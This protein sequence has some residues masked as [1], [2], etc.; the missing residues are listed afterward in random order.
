MSLIDRLHSHLVHSR[1]VRVLS[2]HFA[3]LI[4]Q[5]SLVLDVGCGD[6]L[7]AHWIR[8]KRPDITLQGIDILVREETSIP[9]EAFNGQEIPYDDK[10]FDAVMFVDVLHHTTDPMILLREAARIARKAVLIK[11]HTRNGFFAGPTLRLMDWIGN[12]RHDVA[13]PYNYWTHEQW[14]EALAT[15]NVTIDVWKGALRLYPP[16]ANWLFERGLHFI[17]RLVLR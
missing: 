1:R 13:L 10:S 15:L 14:F 7:V 12:A 5:N 17:A 9:V 8:Q 11:D 16:P 2:D 3:E 4:S 6:G